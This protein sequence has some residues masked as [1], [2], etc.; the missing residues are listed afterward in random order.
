MCIMVGDAYHLQITFHP[1]KIAPPATHFF[2][3]ET[4][5]PKTVEWENRRTCTLPIASRFGCWSFLFEKV[6]CG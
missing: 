3:K 1:P 5:T 2:E 4:P 6:G